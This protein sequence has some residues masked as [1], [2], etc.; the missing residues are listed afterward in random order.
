M[1]FTTYY[2]KVWGNMEALSD[3]TAREFAVSN[4]FM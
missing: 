1:S 4:M 2:N 3:L